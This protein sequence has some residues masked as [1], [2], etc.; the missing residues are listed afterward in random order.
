MNDV[1]RLKEMGI[2]VWALRRP[3]IYPNL[4]EQT[5]NL[6]DGC[7][8]LLVS[9]TLPGGEDA[10]LFEKI[11]ASMKLRVDQARQ[12]PPNALPLVKAHT[13]KW[14][15][16]CAVPEQP[17][18]DGVATLSSPSLAV[19]QGDVSAKKALWQQIKHYDN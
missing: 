6:P 14:V 4:A 10:A 16:F 2:A 9:D 11:L 7:E 5:I 13:L 12:I 1:Q 18:L 15:W 19:L 17:G 3:E 8:L